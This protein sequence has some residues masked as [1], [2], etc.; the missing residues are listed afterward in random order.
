MHGM[1]RARFAC[2]LFVCAVILAAGAAGCKKG[3]GNPPPPPPPPADAGV[4]ARP[5]A[6]VPIV[7]VDIP[8]GFNYPGARDEIQGWADSWAL[9]KIT[10]KAW[11]LWGGMTSATEQRSGGVPLPVWE[12][13]CGNEEVFT[14][15]CGGGKRSRPLRSFRNAVQLTHFAK[16][17]QN[18][19][20]QAASPSDTR[21]ASFNK[22]NPPMANYLQSTQPG[23]GN[24]TYDYTQ[25]TSLAA[26]N[27]AWP[28]T[29][30]IADRKVNETPYVPPSGSEQG[31]SAIETKPVMFL[32]K[33]TGLSPVPLW[34]GIAASVPSANSDC[35]K[36]PDARCHP[37]PNLWTTCVL[38]DPKG[39]AQAGTKPVDAT[40][41]Q[42]ASVPADLLQGMS[43]KKFL[44]APLATIYSFQMNQ[45]EAD[46]FKAAQGNN[47]AA[48]GDYAVLTAMHVN[49]K[50]IVN[51]TWQTYWWQ[52][53]DDP[54]NNF[55]GSKG[56][57]TDKVN[58]AWRNYAM[59]TAYSQTQGAQSKAMVVC[60][61][62]YLETDHSIPDG[63][64][65]NCMSCHGT[66]T[67]GAL[68]SNGINTLGYPEEYRTPINFNTDPRFAKFTRTD[69]SW[70]IP[71]D[72]Q[73][74]STGTAP[75]APAPAPA[76]PK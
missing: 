18:A 6:E 35:S 67:V 27:A 2:D 43:C 58:G 31:L 32:V 15:A 7:A 13:W 54:P 25:Q 26:L 65:S 48:A 38:I 68:G 4:D 46:A 51:W 59:C 74:A 76:A 20:Q 16:T 52:P 11:D 57:M 10:A 73:P 71:Q 40:A 45:Q 12:T 41:E 55:P 24:A 19:T 36:G 14:K 23:P 30:K 72:S 22:F 28:A 63:L 3:D 29:T 49:T 17:T 56:G 50:E 21:L 66:A 75:A 64:Q 62:P 70:A 8:P 5:P 53:G 47:N 33:Q 60:F 61:N 9:S 39:T 37:S 44:Y 69:F 34:Q 1:Q 42:V